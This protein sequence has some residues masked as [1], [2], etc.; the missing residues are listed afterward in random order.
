MGNIILQES[1]WE[2]LDHE[3]IVLLNSTGNLVWM[4]PKGRFSHFV[5]P[6]LY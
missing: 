6:S 5:R 1:E 4:D 3:L 2:S